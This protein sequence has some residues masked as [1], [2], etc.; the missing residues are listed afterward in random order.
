MQVDKI[1]SLDYITVHNIL[2][3]SSITEA[4]K[5]QFVKNNKTEI[6][7]IVEHNIAIT[8]KDFSALMKN[9]PLVKFKPIRNSFTKR[10]DKILLAKTLGIEPNEIPDYIENLR[11]D[12]EEGNSLSFLPEDKF[13]AI[14]TYVYRHGSKDDIVSFLDYELK[15][16]KDVLKTL[17]TTLE[18]HTGGIADYFI[19]PIHRLDN[20]TLVRVYNVID[21]NLQISKKEGKISDEENQKI[22]KWTLY[23]IYQIQNNNKLI[24]AMKTYKTLKG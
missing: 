15:R 5:I 14:K 9:R 13:D 4:Q 16:S 1:S 11:D 21:D 22:A 8:G 19:R 3:S 20:K 12:M 7:K 24:N 6:S 17:Y 18:Y 2:T 23:Q 10:G